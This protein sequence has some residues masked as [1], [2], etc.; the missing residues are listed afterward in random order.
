M[1]TEA[2]IVNQAL[3]FMNSQARITS[4]TDGSVEALAA[5][6][7]Y[8]PTVNLIL[9]QSDPDFAKRTAALTAVSD[10]VPSPWPFGY[11]YPADCIR[12][13]QLMPSAALIAADP[14]DPLPVNWTVAADNTTITNKV[15]YGTVGSAQGV[16][17]SSAVTENQWDASTTRAIVLALASPL[18]M[19]IAGRP[20]FAK[21]ILEQAMAAEQMSESK[22]G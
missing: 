13:R 17:T 16:Y 4:L 2:D 5:Q 11:I 9:R 15:I 18:A 21:S 10:A 1:T 19:A 3:E 7:I 6:V 14:N 20:D 8:T 12:F 22:I